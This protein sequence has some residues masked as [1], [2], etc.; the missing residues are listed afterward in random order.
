MNKTSSAVS[1]FTFTMTRRTR[2]SFSGLQS[3]FSVT[4]THRLC[5]FC[6]WCYQLDWGTNIWMCAHPYVLDH[7]SDARKRL[8]V[9]GIFK[10]RYLAVCSIMT[11]CPY[12]L[13]HKW[14]VL[15]IVGSAFSTCRGFHFNCT[16]A[17]SSS[18]MNTGV[19]NARL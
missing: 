4:L 15:H 9:R 13:R 17:F 6:G 12:I 19:P 3:P 2:T 1:M 7:G 11:S 14:T 10:P 16:A 18:S 8:L 5:L